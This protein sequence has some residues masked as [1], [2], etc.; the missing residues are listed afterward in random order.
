[1]RLK[2]R[3]RPGVAVAVA[4]ALGAALIA[5]APGAQAEDGWGVPLA[6]LDAQK[7]VVGSATTVQ[8]PDGQW[9]TWGVL[10]QSPDALL[11]EIDP[12]AGKVLSSY[13]LDGVIGSWGTEVA[14]D[15]TVWTA[16]HTTGRL[17]SLEY[18][19][20]QVTRTER[21]TPDTSF[22]WELDIGADGIVYGGTYE[23]W[24]EQQPAPA[25]AFGY[26]PETEQFQT[27]G[28][29]DADDT[30]VRATET[31]GEE[32]YVGT[33]STDPHLYRVDPSSGDFESVPP[34]DD[35]GTCQFVYGL[36][37]V[38]SDL[39]VRFNNCG[40]LKN[41]GYVYD[42]VAREWREHT[43]PNYYGTVSEP[44]ADGDVYLVA[45]HILHR[46][47]P[48]TGE[49]EARDVGRLFVNK[50]VTVA[51]DPQTGNETIIA[52]SVDGD[53]GMLDLQT[54]ESEYFVPH[55]M[56]GELGES[57]R[58]SGMSPDGRYHVSV[59]FGGGLGIYDPAVGDWEWHPD[60]GQGESFA[61]LDG[62]A[63]IGVYPSARVYEYDPSQESS[64]GNP[65]EVV[66]LRTEGQDR[67]FGLVAVEEQIAVGTVAGYG[68]RQ[69]ALT[70]VDPASGDHTS[71]RPVE[72]H[73]VISL[74]YRDGVIY[75]GTTIYGGN[76]STPIDDDGR[77]FAWDVESE[78][79]LW[80]SVAI[81]GEKGVGSLTFDDDGR[82]FG[83]TVGHVFE[84][85][86]QT[87]EVLRHDEIDPVD[88]TA[89][90]G[91]WHISDL[92]YDPSD[93]HLY[94]STSSSVYR[95]DVETFED[96]TP[97]PT[98]GSKVRVAP[99]GTKYWVVGRTIYSGVV[100]APDP[101]GALTALETSL[102]D[103]VDSGAVAGPITTRMGTALDLA[104]HHVESGRTGPAIAAMERF[105]RHLNTPTPRDTV[106]QEAHD[107]LQEQATTIVVLLEETSATG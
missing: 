80:Q 41:V 99:D 24:A 62:K 78:E 61:F 96:V 8:M 86:P 103:F 82:L 40:E 46:F 13:P 55:G 107:D 43:I 37:E 69:G 19:A 106:S 68:L 89:L 35:L 101:A 16:S 34:P 7:I 36:E 3:S 59:G 76:G 5:A 91:R 25:Y 2:P 29:F 28:P 52:L 18:G 104:Q 97:E 17:F 92:S 23:G 75:G 51:P 48:A 85:N 65:R 15:G 105:I 94:L 31:V 47:D 67:P 56:S 88:S 102:Q 4:G 45:D 39:Y 9:R 49:L 81:P 1:M 90:Q 70:L 30:Y 71:Y 20:E 84:M 93:G 26:D 57:V 74:A 11:V 22:I 12:F 42:T 58:A 14:P 83:V 79:L 77:V 21:P 87:G 53:L 38:G 27:Y 63:Y 64:D 33:G 44:T 10:N 98:T 95:V 66:D 100:P 60:L 72:D 6:T 73:G 54:G 32:L 50:F